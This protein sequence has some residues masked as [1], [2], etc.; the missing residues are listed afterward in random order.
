MSQRACLVLLCLTVGLAA[1]AAAQDDDP[2]PP[3]E[4]SHLAGPLHLLRCNG[5]VAMV[6]SVGDDGILLVDTGYNGTATAAR[7]AL[8]E[9]DGGP[10]RIIVNTHGDGDHVGGNAVLGEDAV[11][12]SHPATRRQ[13]GRYFALPPLDTAGQP[14]LTLEGN[15]SIHFNGDEIHLLPMPGGHTAGDVVVHFSGSGVACVGD[16]VLTGTFANADP[17]RGG[18]AQRLAEVLRELMDMLPADTTLVPGHGAPQT[19]AELQSYIAMV[20]GTLAAV[21]TDVAAGRSLEEILV[22]QPLT[23]WA[24]WESPENGLSFD[25]WTTE[26]YA[27]LTGDLRQSICAPMTE[28]LTDGG[29]AAAVATYRRLWADEPERWSFAEN[30][31]NTLGYQ[32]LFRD[33]VDEAIAV[34]ELNVE[35]YPDAF[36]TY[37]SLG[38]AYMTAGRTAPAIANYERSL[39]LNPD[40]TNASAML[41]RLT[42]K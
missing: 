4:V 9:L 30:E 7:D 27:S 23:P 10:V 41:A 5:N 16:T 29:V 25:D 20:E 19:V 8:A 38:E 40:N 3:V 22:R 39:E 35:A 6:A 24:E 31:L 12:I 11:I 26:L 15:A 18:D 1:P 37:D 2:P 32:L 13:M 33:K 21:R 14:I 42:G 17:A 28:A 34:L 36:N